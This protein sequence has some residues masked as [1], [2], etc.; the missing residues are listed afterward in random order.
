MPAQE[1]EP[2]LSV[3]EVAVWL[4]L[5]ESTVR[6]AAAKRRLPATR[7]N[8]VWRFLESELRAFL[9]LNHTRA[10]RRLTVVPRHGQQERIDR[11]R[12]TGRRAASR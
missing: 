11:G 3:A 2:Y 4:N 7:V 6:E 9:D 12:T 8:G 1:R 10:V 5:S